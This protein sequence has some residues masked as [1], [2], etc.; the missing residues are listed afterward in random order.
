MRI[1]G[2]QLKELIQEAR[3]LVEGHYVQDCQNCMGT[4]EEDPEM[5]IKCRAC[6]GEG[7]IE[8]VIDPDPEDYDDYE[9]MQ[10]RMSNWA[11]ARGMEW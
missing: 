5:G 4:G 6:K 11:G 10:D 9:E 3:L 2:K 1:T 8:T 7:W